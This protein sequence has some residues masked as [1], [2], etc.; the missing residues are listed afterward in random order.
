[1]GCATVS[2]AAWSTHCAAQ[3]LSAEERLV[4]IRNSLV[5]VA[6]QGPVQVQSTAWIDAQGA[7]QEV[8]SFRSGMQVRGVRVLGYERDTQGEPRANVQIENQGSMPNPTKPAATN[9]QNC[10]DGNKVGH[11][12]HLV[13]LQWSVPTAWGSDDLPVLESARTMLTNYWRQVA[14]D[15]KVWRLMEPDDSTAERSGLAYKSALLGSGADYAPWR[16]KLTLQSAPQAQRTDAQPIGVRLT[17]SLSAQYQAQ[18]ILE[19]SIVLALQ[20]ERSN[21]GV[22]RID[23][24]T[25]YLLQQQ[26]GSWAQTLQQNLACQ[27][28]LPQVMRYSDADIR[29]NAGSAAGVRQG[30]EWL[31]V[32]DRQFPG[33]LLEAGV[34]AQ[35]VL[36]RVKSVAEHQAQLELLAGPVRSVQSRWRAMS[37]E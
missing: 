16:L 12:Q 24:A 1:M 13:A 36:A 15:S 25:E 8:N 14:R 18:P 33:K 32:D 11:L 22:P 5:Q 29:I 26:L 21:W 27:A 17:A 6:L 3:A 7:L 28:V 20:G 2:L 35:S 23:E 9:Q 31:L 34:A 4:A 19:T 37:A 10:T 30:D